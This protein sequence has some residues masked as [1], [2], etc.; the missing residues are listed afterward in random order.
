MEVERRA[1]WPVFF[2]RTC[3]ETLTLL[4][5][6]VQLCAVQASWTC[7]REGW[8]GVRMCGGVQA[9]WM[10][11]PTVGEPPTSL[12]QNIGATREALGACPE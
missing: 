4:P 6:S 12:G 11:P 2:G 9:G 7:W 8:V 5:S 1:A 3:G 10:W